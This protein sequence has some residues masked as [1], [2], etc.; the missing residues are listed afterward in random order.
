M[1]VIIS[2]FYA[3][4]PV[5]ITCLSFLLKIFS[6]FSYQQGTTIIDASQ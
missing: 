5:V 2:K 1:K 6:P 4:F 3:Y